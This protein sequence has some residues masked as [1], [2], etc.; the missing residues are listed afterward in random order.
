MQTAISYVRVSTQTQGRSGLGIEAQ[1]AAIA[2]FADA[3][4]FDL[5]D[6][7]VE[8][9]TGK[10]SEP[11]TAVLGFQQRYLLLVRPPAL[12]SWPNSAVSAEMCISSAVSWPTVCRSL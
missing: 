10:G 4:G 2:R 9:E 12:S 3:E 11:W 1:R 6:E 7:F 5:T 8:V